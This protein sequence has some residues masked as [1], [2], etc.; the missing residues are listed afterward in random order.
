MVIEDLMALSFP[1]IDPVALELGPVVIRWYALAYLAGILL[2]WAYIRWHLKRM[3]SPPLNAKQLEDLIVWA[4]LG[5]MLGG[6]LGYVLFYNAPYYM[7]HPDQILMVWQGGMAFHGGMLGL[8]GAFYLFCRRHGLAFLRVLDLTALAAPIGLFFGRLANFINGE[9]Y[10]RVTDSPLG[11]MFPNG[12]PYPRHPSQL[13][14]AVFEGLL[15][16]VVLLVAARYGK[17]LQRP[18]CIGGMFLA[19]YGLARF[20]V[21][22]FRE[23]DAQLGLLIMNLSMGQLLSLPMIL[24]GGYLI[25]RSRRLPVAEA[26]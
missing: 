16:F 21:E 7:E 1:D 24:L 6:R 8:I 4:V 10:G 11:M 18:G 23:P 12:G 17:T 14:E 22:F 20:S 13:Y 15:L 25:A 3:A 19:G 5:I 9:L 2:G 26:S